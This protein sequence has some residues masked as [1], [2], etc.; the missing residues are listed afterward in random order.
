MNSNLPAA[1]VLRHLLR[2]VLLVTLAAPASAQSDGCVQPEPVCEARD[3]VFAVSAFDPIGSAVRI[4]E[5]RLVTSRHV[6]AD[7]VVVTLFT[8]EGRPLMAQ[9]VPTD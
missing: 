6:V 3:A 2:A 4:G 1:S 5:S 7:E 9:V 8:A